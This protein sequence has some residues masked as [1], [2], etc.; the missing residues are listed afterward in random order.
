MGLQFGFY[1]RPNASRNKML[2]IKKNRFPP[3]IDSVST[4]ASVPR[5]PTCL[6][7]SR[8]DVG[9]RES[10]NDVAAMRC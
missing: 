2:H 6:G 5:K 7:E 3:V 10:G 9:E 1:W 4:I 8:N